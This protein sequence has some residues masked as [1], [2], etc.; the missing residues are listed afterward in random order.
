MAGV[1]AV[2]FDQCP[3]RAGDEPRQLGVHVAHEQEERSDEP[4]RRVVHRGDSSSSS[5][6]SAR[7]PS[8]PPPL[9]VVVVKGHRVRGELDHVPGHD[10]RTP[11]VKVVVVIKS[12][13][14]C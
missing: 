3:G 7:C 8:P 13:A 1:S 9:V 4:V 6:P 2:D 12:G 5:H 11:D 14:F 10:L